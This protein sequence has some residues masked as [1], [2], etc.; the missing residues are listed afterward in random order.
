[1]EE[2]RSGRTGLL[3]FFIGQ[4]VRQ[5]GSGANPDLARRLV[6]ERLEG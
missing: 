5:M 4:V 6:L 2:Y 3:G 1:V